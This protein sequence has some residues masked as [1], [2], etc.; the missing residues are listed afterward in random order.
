[1]ILQSTIKELINDKLE[2][3]GYFLVDIEIQ[4]SNNV[5]VFIDSEKGV[6]IDYCAEIARL[7]EN[8]I[9]REVEDY[10]LE[11]SSSG[12]GQP[13][14]VLRQYKKNL[15][16]EVEVLTDKKVKIKGI[17]TDASE[18]SFQIK[19]EKRVKVA[20]AKKKELQTELHKFGYEEI[21]YVKE[22][23]RF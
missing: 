1:M 17:L 14:K 7:I 19:E 22:L 2:V 3:D 16:K 9:D 18:E 15:G 20:G 5:I 6:S 12:I 11:V 21:K 13:F 23:I 8:S 4:P 10:S